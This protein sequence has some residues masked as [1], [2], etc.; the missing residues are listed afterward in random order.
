M[1]QEREN[2]FSEW[3]LLTVS[4]LNETVLITVYGHQTEA[5]LT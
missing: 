5:E 3:K 2:I 1:T 4:N